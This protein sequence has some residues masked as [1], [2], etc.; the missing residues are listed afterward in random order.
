[1]DAVP[2]VTKEEQNVLLKASKAGHRCHAHTISSKG[3][4]DDTNNT[5]GTSGLHTVYHLFTH[6]L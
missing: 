5:H 4:N 1:M 6:F 3:S 2:K